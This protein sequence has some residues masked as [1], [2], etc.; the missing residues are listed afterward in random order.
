MNGAG[1]IRTFD[2]CEW[3]GNAPG[4][5]TA[6]SHFWAQKRTHVLIMLLSDC[7]KLVT[8][9]QILVTSQET[10]QL[11]DFVYWIIILRNQSI[12]V[13]GFSY[14]NICVDARRKNSF[15]CGKCVYRNCTTMMRFVPLAVRFRSKTFTHLN[16][17]LESILFLIKVWYYIPSVIIILN[18][19]SCF[20]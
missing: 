18:I 8:C 7:N 6:P 4:G 15:V 3:S 17:S 1:N 12:M 14:Y 20:F 9:R 16:K 19:K 2:L 10:K 5:K 11:W 13:I